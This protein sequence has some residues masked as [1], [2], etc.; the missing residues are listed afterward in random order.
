MTSVLFFL[1][2]PRPPRSTL[3]PY[4]TLFRSLLRILERA[5]SGELIGEPPGFQSTSVVGH[6]IPIAEEHEKVARAALTGG[7]RRGDEA[8]DALRV[9]SHDRVRRARV[10][11]DLEP[12]GGGRRSETT[13]L[14]R[15]VGRLLAGRGGG[16]D[17]SKRRVDEIAQG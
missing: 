16:K 9:L 4:T 6:A 1:M 5:A 10:G 17:R 12:V 3:F 2:I 7:D 14:E 15:H 13:R 11:T 8:C